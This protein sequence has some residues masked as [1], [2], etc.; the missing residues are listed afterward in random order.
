MWV[1]YCGRDR[2]TSTKKLV[3]V[4]SRITVFWASW[5]AYELGIQSRVPT[6]SNVG[7]LKGPNSDFK[8]TVSFARIA[9]AC[10]ISVDSYVILFGNTGLGY[11]GFYILILT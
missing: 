3:S 9:K 8:Y 7:Q 5:E 1:F 2:D 4:I 10:I 6:S 11:V